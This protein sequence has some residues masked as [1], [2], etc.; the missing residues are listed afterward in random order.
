MWA[1]SEARRSR[2]KTAVG[3]WLHTA[4][5][6]SP[7]LLLLTQKN[8]RKNKKLQ[9]KRRLQRLEVQGVHRESVY[10]VSVSG[11]RSTYGW[12]LINTNSQTKRDYTP[13]TPYTPHT[14]PQ[15]TTTN[16]THSKNHT[17]HC[18]LKTKIKTGKIA[19]NEHE[20]H[21]HGQRKNRL[22]T[23]HTSTRN[24]NKNKCKK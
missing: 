19:K 18:K 2:R 13:Y 4:A 23:I 8:E 16:T 22:K 12:W 6:L 24:K 21:R 15:Q 7:L 3:F 11:N 20:Q 17:R 9:T 10:G 14:L 5:C 1:L